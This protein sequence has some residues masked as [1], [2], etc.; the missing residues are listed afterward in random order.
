MFGHYF[1]TFTREKGYGDLLSCLG[2]NLFEFLNNLNRLHNHL[3]F[4]MKGLK[5]PDIW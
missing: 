5:L 4:E 3:N 1:L 2:N